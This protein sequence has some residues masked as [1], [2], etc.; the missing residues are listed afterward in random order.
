M[1]PITSD[2]LPDGLF[3]KNYIKPS[4]NKTK[5]HK[6]IKHPITEILAVLSSPE[7]TLHFIS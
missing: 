2:K 1:C 7:M 6:I 3:N 5:P 4:I